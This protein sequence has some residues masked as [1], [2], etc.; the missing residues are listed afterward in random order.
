MQ[1]VWVSAAIPPAR[2]PKRL[3]RARGAGRAGGAATEERPLRAGPAAAAPRARPS[4]PRA[5]RGRGRSL[6][7]SRCSARGR[8][9]R[10]QWGAAGR[11]GLGGDWAGPGPGRGPEGPEPLRGRGGGRAGAAAAG[12]ARG[13]GCAG[14]AAPG[15]GVTEPR[16]G[17][18]RAPVRSG[19]GRVAG[20]VPSLPWVGSGLEG[21]QPCG[22]RGAASRLPLTSLLKRNLRATRG[23]GLQMGQWGF[24]LHIKIFFCCWGGQ[25]LA[26]VARGGG[27]CRGYG[28]ARSMC[29][30]WIRVGR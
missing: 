18:D 1:N 3:V 11:A 13:A 6:R 5:Q 4:A 17:T 8:S 30:E 26:Q 20:R 28:Q 2:W 24:G 19:P 21:S 10:R 9:A 29:G 23:S 16:R 22:Q 15:E 14:G 27:G 7:R 12:R 25:A